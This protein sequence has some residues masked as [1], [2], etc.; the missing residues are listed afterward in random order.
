[1]LKRRDAEVFE[2]LASLDNLVADAALLKGG[3]L[4]GSLSIAASALKAARDYIQNNPELRWSF[5]PLAHEPVIAA[6]RQASILH[7]S[8]NGVDAAFFAISAR[9]SGVIFAARTAPP[10]IPS[11]LAA[12]SF[13]RRPAPTRLPRRSLSASREPRCRSYRRGAS[14]L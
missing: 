5:L 9:R 1:M 14:G 3:L 13:R 12:G 7:C 11:A 10:F 4:G 8:S 6:E 2:G